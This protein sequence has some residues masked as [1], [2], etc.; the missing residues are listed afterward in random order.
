MNKKI[1]LVTGGGGFIGTNLVRTLQLQYKVVVVDNFQTGNFDQIFSISDQ[2]QTKILEG[3]ICDDDT[4]EKVVDLGPYDFILH[5]ACPASPPKYQIDQLD[6]LETNFVGTRNILNVAKKMGSRIV[7]AS[8]S[9]VYGD[10]NV[11]PQPETYRGNVNT[12]GPR[13]CYD[14][15][16]RIAETLCYVFREQFGV[17]VGLVRIFNTYG[18]YMDIN[19]GRVVTSFIK[20]MMTNSPVEIYGDGSQTRSLCF[21]D[22]LIVGLQ[23]YLFSDL[24]L[25]INLGCDKEITIKYLAELISS[26]A[27]QQ[28][29]V[30]YKNLPVDDP[31]QRRPDLTQ[32]I[33]YLNWNPKF[34]LEQ[35]LELTYNFFNKK[36]ENSR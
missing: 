17:N 26:L 24:H 23:T 12:L 27:N 28:L 2:N 32:A 1:I 4:I 25:P 9:E 30:S 13:A 14:E 33:K 29:V 15:G 5:L 36:Y 3:N 6:T 16:K 11:N 18:P 31:K 10:P 34:S 19:D 20:S 35:G 7:I 22:D 8:T 21:V